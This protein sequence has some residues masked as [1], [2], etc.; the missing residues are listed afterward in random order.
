MRIRA[1]PW[2]LA[3]GDVER[4]DR[5]AKT[6][7]ARYGEKP[8]RVAGYLGC[9]RDADDANEEHDGGDPAAS[10]ELMTLRQP[11]LDRFHPV[12]PSRA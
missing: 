5:D 12:N 7:Q 4:N 1:C 9:H 8:G 6:R 10:Q 11:V 2:P 3:M